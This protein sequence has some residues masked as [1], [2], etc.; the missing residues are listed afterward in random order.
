MLLR[1]R[2]TQARR[3]PPTPHGSVPVSR[4]QPGKPV[5]ARHAKPGLCRPSGQ[6]M[7]ASSQ[8]SSPA[9][10]TARGQRLRR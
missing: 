5:V 9:C 1:L 6:A 8:N 3:Q 2:R 10:R 7:A 4:T